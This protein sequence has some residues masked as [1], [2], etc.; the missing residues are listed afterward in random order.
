MRPSKL[1]KKLLY[2]T[3][4]LLALSGT[5]WIAAH[6]FMLIE[7]EYGP[8]K[9]PLEIWSLRLHGLAGFITLLCLGMLFE[10]GEALGVPISRSKSP[11]PSAQ[12]SK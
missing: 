7:G 5:A 6:Y 2:P 10:F 4:I 11:K 9:H 12:P 8:E 3:L 1:V